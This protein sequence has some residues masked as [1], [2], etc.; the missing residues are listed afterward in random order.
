MCKVHGDIACDSK[1][2]ATT[3]VSYLIIMYPHNDWYYGVFKKNEVHLYVLI[4]ERSTRNIEFKKQE[5]KQQVKHS[6]NSN[7]KRK[8]QQ[9]QKICIHTH[10][11]IHTYTHIYVRFLYSYTHAEILRV[12]HLQNNTFNIIYTK[13]K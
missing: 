8:K 2:L 6:P 11:R 13:V 10:T 7:W 4:L 3:C 9:Q 5:A 1:R 12:L